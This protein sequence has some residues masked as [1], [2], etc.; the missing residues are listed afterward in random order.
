MKKSEKWRIPTAETATELTKDLPFP[1]IEMRLNSIEDERYE[2]QWI[3]GLVF[4]EFAHKT[5]SGLPKLTFLPISISFERGGWGIRP[6][7]PL[8]KPFRDNV[9]MMCDMFAMNLPGY[10]VCEE[11]KRVEEIKI[12]PEFIDR[13]QPHQQIV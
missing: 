11:A 3:Y 2:R 9:N 4:Y 8:P 5:Y 7:Y 13:F 6:D 12:D 10:I 1:R